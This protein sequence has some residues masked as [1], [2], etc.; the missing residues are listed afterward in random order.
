[1]VVS[2]PGCVGAT[3]NPADIEPSSQ[4]E[5]GWPGCLGGSFGE[6]KD[7]LDNGTVPSHVTLRVWSNISVDSLYLGQ[8]RR[9]V[10]REGISLQSGMAVRTC[11][12]ACATSTDTRK[13]A[14]RSK[15]AIDTLLLL[16]Q[17][18][19]CRYLTAAMHTGR[20]TEFS[21]CSCKATPEILA[22]RVTLA[23][24]GERH[25]Q[26]SQSIKFCR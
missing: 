17:S 4:M 8:I 18:R 13:F 1:M 14:N 20:H 19:K 12:P 22:G 23:T 25:N 2:N 16:F 5:L 7:N 24:D 10:I 21:S 15:H 11:S 6:R 3:D 9:S 26:L